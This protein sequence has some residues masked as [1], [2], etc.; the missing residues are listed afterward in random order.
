MPNVALTTFE[1]NTKNSSI[2]LTSTTNFREKGTSLHGVALIVPIRTSLPG[3]NT[4]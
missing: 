3:Q 1:S 2:Y 4:I